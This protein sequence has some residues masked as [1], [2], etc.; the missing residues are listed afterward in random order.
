M[1]IAG[2][3]VLVLWSGAFVAG[4][5]VANFSFDLRRPYDEAAFHPAQ[6]NVVPGL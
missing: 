2:K 6:D 3:F 1:R 4:L 5:I